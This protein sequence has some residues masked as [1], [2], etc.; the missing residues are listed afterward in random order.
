VLRHNEQHAEGWQRWTDRV[1]HRGPDGL[2]Q[3]LSAYWRQRE[4]GLVRHFVGLV[5]MA[6]SRHVA[7]AL[8]WILAPAQEIA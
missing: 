1:F 7:G 4:P 2:A 3:P 5:R 6:E 8:R